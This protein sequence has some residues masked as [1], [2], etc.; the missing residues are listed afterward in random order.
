MPYAAIQDMTDRFTETELKRL[1]PSA[2]PPGYDAVR[3]GRAID[4]ASAEAD[5]YLAVRFSVPLAEAP[6]LLVKAV[7]DLAREA[8]DAQG[9]QPVVDAAKRAR[10][11]LK[12]LA[13]G[14]ATLGSGPD[15]DPGALP[16]STSGGAVVDA[17]ARVFTDET[18]AGFLS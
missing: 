4:D 1:A 8:L 7:C 3:V 12:D 2:S 14:R 16:D 10:Q 18:L 17:P 6:P 11:W 15:G 13:A 9:R 5:S